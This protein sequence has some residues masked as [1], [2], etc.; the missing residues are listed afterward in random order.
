MTITLLLSFWRLSN[1]IGVGQELRVKR[2]NIVKSISVPSIISSVLFV[3]IIMM[4]SGWYIALA[5]IVFPFLVFITTI[6][7]KQ[8]ITFFASLNVVGS[9]LNKQFSSF[10]V[11]SGLMFIISWLVYVSGAAAIQILFVNDALMMI[12]TNDSVVAG[13]ITLGLSAFELAFS[14]MIYVVLTVASNYIM[15][16]TFFET[17]SAQNLLH[18]I[19]QIKLS[20]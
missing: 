5:H 7:L 14:S 2:N 16:Y 20:K 17:Y 9:L 13:K 15:Y 3:L 11:V 10:I 12:L 18:R 4:D 1:V 19:S 6:C 8:N